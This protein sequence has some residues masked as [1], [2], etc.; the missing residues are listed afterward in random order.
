M[1]KLIAKGVLTTSL[2]LFCLGISAQQNW[3]EVVY[4]KNGSIIKGI[5]V[6]QNPNESIKVRTSD[7]S[8]FVYPISDVEKITKEMAP[9]RSGR[10]Y[11]SYGSEN[12]SYSSYSSSSHGAHKSGY[13]GFA[14]FGY[15]GN[16]SIALTTS[17]GYQFNDHIFLG[18][19]L[20]Y[21]YN[22]EYNWNKFNSMLL[23]THFRYDI[24]STFATPFIDLK[25]G[26][27]FSEEYDDYWDYYDGSGFYVS[28]TVG[29]RLGFTEKF[30]LNFGV[31]YIY[32]SRD[33]GS[34]NGG[35]AVFRIGVDF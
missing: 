33:R 15:C 19:G 20:G 5:V 34:F 29:C 16:S 22:F 6:E 25:M 11:D 4:L 18:A 21:D 30:G 1:K 35:G 32:Q 23:Y 8:L 9:N 13:R 17:H 10:A 14:E 27:T 24:I 3:T 31:G 12:S 28:P 7:G 2:S 26:Y